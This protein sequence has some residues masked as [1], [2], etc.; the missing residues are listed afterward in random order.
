MILTPTLSFG[1]GVSVDQAS[2][3]TMILVPQS[4]RIVGGR[5]NRESPSSGFG[6]GIERRKTPQG[7][8]YA[9]ASAR[10]FTA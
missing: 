5:S 9:S 2:L 7:T 1:F 3:K 8:R 4:P 6:T 10:M